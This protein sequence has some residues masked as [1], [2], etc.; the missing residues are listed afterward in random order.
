[1][2]KKHCNIPSTVNQGQ[3]GKA[4]IKECLKTE[5]SLQRRPGDLMSSQYKSTELTML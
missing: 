1:M 5:S 4:D 3:R 2:D